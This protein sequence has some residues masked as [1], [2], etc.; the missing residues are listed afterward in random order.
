MMEDARLRNVG[1]AM[2]VT[3]LIPALGWADNAGPP[4]TLDEWH[5]AIVVADKVVSAADGQAAL[6][7][8]KQ[9]QQAGERPARGERAKLLRLRIHAALAVGN[10]GQAVRLLPQLDRAG[11]DDGENVKTAW[12]VALS[13][14]DAYVAKRV[15]NRM[16]TGRKASATA[17]RQRMDR[18]EHIGEAAPI[19]TVQAE[20][21]ND[22]GLSERDGKVLVLDFW[23]TREPP[24]DKVVAAMIELY[25]SLAAEEQVEFLGINS[26]RPSQ[27]EAAR[28]LAVANGY[29]WPQHYERK[30]DEAPLTETAF[31]VKDAPWQVVIDAEGNV[32]NV[33]SVLDPAFHYALRA[34]V[35]E[36]KGEYEPIRPKNLAGKQAKSKL[37]RLKE[38][39]KERIEK[40]KDGKRGRG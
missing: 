34:A 14:G 18:L 12:L 20:S 37:E 9:W 33:G 2:V 16:R 15:L 6:D 3:L 8:I 13:S 17:V 32:R 19:M 35:A 26:D 4:A 36:A 10:V 23:S 1:L 27:V 29:K 40:R 22:V 28:K 5:D 39:I 30:L 24:S 7:Q 21:G 11:G 31:G 25:D 38:R